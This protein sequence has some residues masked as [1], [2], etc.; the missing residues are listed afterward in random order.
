M[1]KCN[2]KLSTTQR[3][4]FRNKLNEARKLMDCNKESIENRS[5]VWGEDDD[6]IYNAKH[7]SILYIYIYIQK[8]NIYIQIIVFVLNVLQ[9]GLVRPWTGEK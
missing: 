7:I 8:P 6:D 2:P 5:L 9:I 1:N 4:F 3:K